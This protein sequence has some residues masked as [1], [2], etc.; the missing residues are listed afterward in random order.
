MFDML[1]WS[2]Q[3]INVC[4][5]NIQHINV[6]KYL[7]INWR[8]IHIKM[9]VLNE[10]SS[11]SSE[12]NSLIDYDSD[13]D[14]AEAKIESTFNDDLS[15]D[16]DWNINSSHVSPDLKLLV[17]N[18]GKEF[19]VGPLDVQHKINY[20]PY[21][22]FSLI[23]DDHLFYHFAEQ[24]DKYIKTEKFKDKNTEL[25]DYFNKNVKEIDHNAIKAYFAIILLMGVKKYPD[26]FMHWSTNKT[27]MDVK[28][29]EIMPSIMYKVI[30]MSFH[31]CDNSSIDPNDP[32]FKVSFFV[33]YRI[34]S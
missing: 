34:F 29:R 24:S 8:Q 7:K 1:L 21:E 32:F 22:V 14:E 17:S 9:D 10:S 28:I 18:F 2:I 3:H 31:I 12:H 33:K 16:T 23:F 11:D 6:C 19:A 15:N 26:Q 30:K 4:I 5:W 27:F 25:T 13:F 20:S